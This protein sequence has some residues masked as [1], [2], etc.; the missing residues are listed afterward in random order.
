VKNVPAL[1]VLDGGTQAAGAK[2]KLSL[3]EVLR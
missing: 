2:D 3:D 1:A